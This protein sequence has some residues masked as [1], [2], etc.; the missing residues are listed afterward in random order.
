MVPDEPDRFGRMAP[1]TTVIA[2]EA[3]AVKSYKSDR[4]KAFRKLSRRALKAGGSVWL[5][6][7]TP[8]LNNPSELWAMLQAL[9]MGSE[10]YGE[11]RKFIERFGGSQDGLGTVTWD[12]SA[13]QPGAVD[14]IRPYAIRRTRAEVMPQLPTK[15]R[16]SVSMKAPRK[17]RAMD[18]AWQGP[19]TDIDDLLLRLGDDPGMM[20]DRKTLAV[21][22]VP[23]LLDL[24]AEYESARE[25]LVVFSAHRAP[26]EALQ[27]RQGWAAIMGGVADRQGIADRFQAGELRGLACTIRAAGVGLTLTRA[28]HAV[29][30]DRDWTPAMNLQAEDRLVR[31]GQTRGVVI[32]DIVSDHPLDVAVTR[33]LIE[34]HAYHD[35]TT[36]LLE[37]PYVESD[38]LQ[39]AL[40][41]E[42]IADAI[43]AA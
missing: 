27:H 39:E 25:P 20:G 30:V 12:A 4:T 19:A 28:A 38:K 5:L 10:L 13:V 41:L 31:I 14:P 2:D 1:S 11:H 15:L 40:E 18:A 7:G 6:T 42:A 32:T 9:G 8:L 16:R 3:Q 34:K 24:V 22:K 33:T 35:A 23:M 36:A 26:V 17:L 21:H 43:D 29:F 37:Q